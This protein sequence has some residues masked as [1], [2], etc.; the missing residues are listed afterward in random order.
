MLAKKIG[1]RISIP[2]D[3]YGFYYLI[4][5]GGGIIAQQSEHYLRFGL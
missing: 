1:D 4:T 2:Y 3:E 5:N